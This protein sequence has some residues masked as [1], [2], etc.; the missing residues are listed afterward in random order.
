MEEVQGY[1]RRRFGL[2]DDML[3]KRTRKTWFA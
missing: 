1:G 3:K 2:R